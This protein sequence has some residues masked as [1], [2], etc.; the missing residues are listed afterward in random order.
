MENLQRKIY[1][2]YYFE[3]DDFIGL[4]VDFDCDFTYSDHASSHSREQSAFPRARVADALP[5]WLIDANLHLWIDS[6]GDS[7]TAGPIEYRDPRIRLERESKFHDLD[8]KLK[9]EGETKREASGWVKSS[10]GNLTTR[11]YGKVEF[12][13]KLVLKHGGRKVRVRQSVRAVDEVRVRSEAGHS[14]AEM[15]RER[16][17]PLQVRATVMPG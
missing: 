13:S 9:V 4:L 11:V 1:S 17:Y 5:Y 6:N 10:A 14:V 2:D 15:G 3:Y 7:V 8:G 16:R 12:E